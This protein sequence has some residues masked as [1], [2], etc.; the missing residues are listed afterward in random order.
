[1]DRSDRV[2]LLLEEEIIPDKIQRPWKFS[3]NAIST[4]DLGGP[5][6]EGNGLVGIT[7]AETAT[8]TS[9]VNGVIGTENKIGRHTRMGFE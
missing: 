9:G 4:L 8:E 3:E 6:I 5:E 2:M 7:S 1:M